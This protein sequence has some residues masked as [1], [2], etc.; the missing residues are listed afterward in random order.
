MIGVLLFVK[1]SSSG[2][3]QESTYTTRF[4]TRYPRLCTVVVQSGGRF[5]ITVGFG[6][7]VSP[8]QVPAC[9]NRAT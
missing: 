6:C 8:Q 7:L 3:V 9:T 2:G 5:R 1:I 4:A